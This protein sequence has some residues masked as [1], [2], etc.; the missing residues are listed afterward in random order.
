M[1]RCIFI[2]GRGV[3]GGGRG[4]RKKGKGLPR[5]VFV[6]SPTQ[7]PHDCWSVH[8]TFLGLTLKGVMSVIEDSIYWLYV[9]K[10]GQWSVVGASMIGCGGS[11]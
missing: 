9:N 10:T 4:W 3:G 7:P 11:L 6:V 8:H 2:S 5:D 1:A